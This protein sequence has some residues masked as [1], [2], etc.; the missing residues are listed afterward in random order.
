MLSVMK[1]S[2]P[3]LLT[4]RNETVVSV[5]MRGISLFPAQS[6]SLCSFGVEIVLDGLTTDIEETNRCGVDVPAQS[7][8]PCSSVDKIARIRPV[9]LL[10]ELEELAPG[11]VRIRAQAVID[12]K[13]LGR[14]NHG[15]V[16]PRV[17]EEG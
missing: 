9:L 11:E 3:L 7:F 15:A 6:C 14:W 5:D 8:S 16:Q 1:V 2:L 13:Q 12:G 4:V 10:R 17:Q